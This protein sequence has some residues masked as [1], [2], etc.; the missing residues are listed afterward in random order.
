MLADAI[1]DSIRKGQL[2]PGDVLP[3]TRDL[4]RKFQ[5]HRHTVMSA[6]GEL[7]AE[8]WI[9]AHA[10]RFYQV[11]SILPSKFL[12]PRKMLNRAISV[13][14]IS[15]SFGRL[16]QTPDYV[17][18]SK[19]KY[20]FPSGFPDLRL[21]PMREFKS[22]LYDALRSP[23]VLTYASPAGHERLIE[24]IQDYLRRVRAVDNRS[25]VVTNGSQEALFL[26]A[27]LLIKPGDIVAVEALGYPPAIEALRFA[28]AKL[29]PI[30][31]DL[32][33]LDVEELD[34]FSKK[35]KI[36]AVYTTPLH[37]YPTTVSLTAVRRLQLYEVAVKN[38][39][40]ILEDDYDH[41][42]HYTNQPVSPLASFDPASIVL[43]ISTFS[44]VLFP[45]AR[46]GF[47]AI[48]P[49]IAHE[50]SKLKRISSRQNETIL[51]DAIA[52]W[53]QQGEFE[54]HLRKM[55]RIYDERRLKMLADLR[56][57]QTR[58]PEISWTAPSGGMALW[59]ETKR[60]SF[61]LSERAA[62]KGVLV[63]AEARFRVDAKAG[64]H[65]RL[66]FSG[67]TPQENSRGLEELFSLF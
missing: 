46:I 21:F 23:G 28:G 33:G 48:P 64:T 10:K 12:Q 30:S 29:L 32:H 5:M 22:C 9:T 67:Q 54:K 40:L 38:R 1:R 43:Y 53:M 59:L 34:K 62:K 52:R 60:N 6:I 27:Q 49:T 3:S 25:I 61:I 14:K 50:M 17:P 8:G 24:Q 45:S 18:S 2:R 57:H 31:V 65:L 63:N 51:Q 37:Q 26:L 16:A 4:G 44:K 36:K 39:I 13:D 66:G 7:Q 11:N 42:F 41:E 20:A 55:R 56:E 58:H 35:H 15:F 19:Y 47:A